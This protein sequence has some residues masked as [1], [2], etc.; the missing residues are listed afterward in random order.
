[1]KIYYCWRCCQ[2]MPFLEEHEWSAVAPHLTHYI[3][4][5]KQYRQ[6]NNVDLATAR[7]E[8]K[9]KAT[10]IFEEITGYKSIHP[11]TITHHRLKNWGAECSN[12]GHL[13]RTQNAVFCAHCGHPSE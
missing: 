4:D 11:E 7:R 2:M 12:C 6:E 10:E 9:F 13:L 5:I 8:M 3:E 1:M